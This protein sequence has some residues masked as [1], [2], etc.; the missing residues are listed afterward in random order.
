MNKAFLLVFL[1]IISIIVPDSKEAALAA[2]ED[3]SDTIET[4]INELDTEE[5][6]KYLDKLKEEYGSALTETVKDL[7]EGILYQREGLS[8]ERFFKLALNIFVGNIGGVLAQISVII[9]ACLLLSLLKNLS[10]GFTSHSTD[11][12]VQLAC[13]SVVI[14][15]VLSITGTVIQDVIRTI[16]MLTD[17]TQI[18]F[19]PILTVM[20]AIG[21]VSAGGIYQPLLAFFSG[22]I[23]TVIGTVILP[24]FYLSF[25]LSIVARLSDEIKLSKLIKTVNS[26][27]KWILSLVFGLFTTL[28]SAKGIVGEGVDSFAVRS[29]KNALSGYVPVVGDYLKDGFDIVITSFMIVKSALGW[30]A[31][32]FLIL[33]VLSPLLKTL[34][35][36]FSLKLASS[37][38]EPFGANVIS[39]ML[40]DLSESMKLLVT[41]LLCVFFALF[42]IIMLLLV[43]ANRGVI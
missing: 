38:A 43:S 13:F 37:I 39:E 42:V 23:L 10:S 11:K 20:T 16:T 27:A 12:V 2:E 26:A 15:V 5:Y 17:F 28:L 34:I 25:S 19:P 31:L 8:T 3:I 30:V 40:F 36:M 18:V 4:I 1:A 22:G 35:A 24:L 33:T 32:L 6:E 7:I 41:V 14:T 29:A 9:I 21:S